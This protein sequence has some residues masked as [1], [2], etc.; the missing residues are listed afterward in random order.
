MIIGI[1]PGVKG[2]L[3][4][5]G[6]ENVREVIA[7]PTI[8]KVLD[9]QD[10]T[11]FIKKWLFPGVLEVSNAE[12][13]VIEKVHTFNKAGSTQSFSFGVGYGQLQG[14]CAALQLPFVLVTSQEWKRVILTGYK[15]PGKGASEKEKKAAALQ[16]VKQKYP[17]L[18]L[19]KSEKCRN[20]HDGIVDAICLAEYGLRLQNNQTYKE[21]GATF[22]LNSNGGVR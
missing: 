11:A 12:F 19:R 17:K 21:K 20:P 3:A 4:A 1:D 16:Y 5:M 22:S 14:I 6:P 13:I 2:G 9:L 15:K 7:M 10:I 8:G 18:D